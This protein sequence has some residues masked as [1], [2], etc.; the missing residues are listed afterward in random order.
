MNRRWSVGAWIFVRLLALVHVIAFVSFARQ[1][2]GLIGPRGI[3]PAGDFFSAVHQGFGAAAFWKLPSLCWWLGTQGAIPALAFAGVGVA[4]LVFFGFAPGPGLL[5]LWIDYLSLAGAGQVFYNFQWDALLLETTLLAVFFA[6]WS[7]RAGW[8]LAEPPRLARWLVW[9]LLFRLMV[10]SGLVKLASGDPSWR[11][12][13]A[14]FVHFQT[15]PLPTPVA[16]YAAHLP[17][18]VLRAACALMFVIELG[19]PFCLCAGPRVRRA[20]LLALLLFQGLIELTGNY[21]FFNL[22]TAALCLT[23]LDDGFWLKLAGVLPRAWRDRLDGASTAAPRPASGRVLR[24]FAA[25]AIVVTSL[26]FTADFVPAVAASPAVDDLLGLTD[27]SRSLNSYG[28][29]AVM[30]AERPEL[31]FEGSDDGHDWLPYGFPH[32]PGNL[33]RRPDFVAPGQPRLDWQ[34]WFAALSPPED[35]PWVGSFVAALLQG[36][37]DVLALVATDPFPNRPP[38]YVR[39]V[40]YIYAFSSPAD[41][42]ASG[43]WWNRVFDDFYLGPVSLRD[44]AAAGESLR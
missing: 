22:L 26:E 15:Q 29:F 36:D 14:L 33:R 13:S 1:W 6:P 31:I 44:G 20:C 40:R 23:A 39:V 16:W 28:L 35:N 34:L 9:W 17:H 42:K 37:P 10:L 32:K 18:A 11:N 8:K 3:L 38:R 5:F 2:R 19:A 4:L 30:T 7:L 24:A 12:L 25:V 27:S 43:R 41:R 21:A